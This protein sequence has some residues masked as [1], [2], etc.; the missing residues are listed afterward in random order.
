METGL[1]RAIQNRE[2]TVDYQ[3]QF[4]IRSGLPCGVEALLRWTMPGG[5]AV[6]PS[7]F[8]PLAEQTGMIGTLGA[9][10]LEEACRTVAAWHDPAGIP[11]TLCVNVSTQQI[12]TEFTACLARVIDVTHFPADCL[13]LE[14]TESVLMQSAERTLECLAAWKRLGIRVAVDDF[15]SGYSS[16]SYL[17][18]LPVDRLKVDRSLVHSITTEPKAAAIVRTIILLG[19]EL[20][21]TVLAEGVETEAQFEMLSDLGCQQMQ[22]YLTARPA[23]SAQARA[24]LQRH[25]GQRPA[26]SL[27]P[28]R[29]MREAGHAR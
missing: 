19:R 8:V 14:I 29:I 23:P 21:F 22:G 1:R 3:P 9:W 13:E 12:C 17:S 28:Q 15:G 10:V 16:L 4:E 7:V 11:L 18:Q 5:E 6:S 27:R 25:W 20:G 2:F 24:T 26:V